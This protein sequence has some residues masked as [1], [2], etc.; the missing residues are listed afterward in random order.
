MRWELLTQNGRSD[1]D[2]YSKIQV[3]ELPI[4]RSDERQVNER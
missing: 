2:W 3:P 1:C 4:S